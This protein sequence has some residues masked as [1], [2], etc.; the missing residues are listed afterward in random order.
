MNGRE[1][2]GDLLARD[3]QGR[4]SGVEMIAFQTHLE[5]CAAC[6]QDQQVFADF[7]DTDAVDLHDGDRIERL[8]A[9]ARRWAHLQPGR[10]T[11]RARAWHVRIL[12]VAASLLF[13]VGMASAALWWRQAR[14]PEGK[15][16]RSAPTPAIA[17]LPLPQA[18]AGPAPS[19]AAVASP[20]AQPMIEARPSHAARPPRQELAV[21]AQDL[22]RQASEAR[23]GGDAKRAILLYRELQNDFSGTSES[24]VAAIPLGGLLLDRGLSRAALAQYDSYLD[25]TRAGSAR[26]GVL[27]PEALYGRG[28]ALQMLGDRREERQNWEHLLGDFADSAY[29]PLARRRLAELK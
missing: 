7:S 15:A 28:R 11:F 4:L 24:L 29:A 5:E 17:P 27:R 13:M 25:S 21:S 1:C 18:P 9:T 16:P 19:I 14:G 2:L 3:R 22:L 20:P 12:A 8:S 26:A 6:R 10:T 23:R